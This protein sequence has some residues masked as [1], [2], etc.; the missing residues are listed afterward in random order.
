MLT[1]R[2]AIVV[3]S[4][5]LI[6]CCVYVTWSHCHDLPPG[7]CENL[8]THLISDN[9][10]NLPLYNTVKYKVNVTSHPDKED[11]RNDVQ[12]AAGEWHRLYYNDGAG[13]SGNCR[14]GFK[15]DG[16]TT[17]HPNNGNDGVNTIGYGHL[18]W[19]H[20]NWVPGRVYITPLFKHQSPHKRCGYAVQLLSRMGLSWPN[21]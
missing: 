17:T 10:W 11:L 1:K 3:L 14:F 21:R 9:F 7:T 5:L 12:T 20:N 2:I 18:P 6:G 19:E 15:Y 4:V 13:T 8:T 16:T